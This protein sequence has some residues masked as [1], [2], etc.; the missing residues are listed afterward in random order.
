MEGGGG[1]FFLYLKNLSYAIFVLCFQFHHS[2]LII[3]TLI[4]LIYICQKYIRVVYAP[5]MCML[6]AAMF[7]NLHKL[8][9]QRHYLKLFGSRLSHNIH[10]SLQGWFKV[11]AWN[12]LDKFYLE[13]SCSG[14]SKSSYTFHYA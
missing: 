5:I 3:F 4:I 9:T 7:T 13:T 1:E 8:S 2:I 12:I 6:F 10:F 11:S 14:Y